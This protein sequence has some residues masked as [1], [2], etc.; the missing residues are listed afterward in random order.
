M[1]S[2]KEEKERGGGGGGSGAEDIPGAW[3]GGEEDVGTVRKDC[4]LLSWE[5]KSSAEE[6]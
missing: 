4:S 1:L 2:D 6:E 5:E 3:A